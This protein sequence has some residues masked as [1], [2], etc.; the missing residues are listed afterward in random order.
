MRKRVL[1]NFVIV[2]AGLAAAA[3][4]SAKLA[5]GASHLPR[6]VTAIEGLALRS[7]PKTGSK[8]VKRLGLLTEVFVLKRAKQPATIGGRKDRW[9]YVQANYCP[10]TKDKSPHCETLVAKGWVADSLLAFDERFEPM[11]KWRAGRIEASARNDSWSYAIA[12]DAS[13]AFEREAWRYISEGVPCP[14]GKRQGRYCLEIKSETGRLYR[15]RNVVRAGKYGDLL[16]IDARGA[17]CDR[18][19]Y[20][21]EQEI[22]DR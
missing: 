4:H 1:R 9:V 14:G 15:Y 7:A 6:A 10:D 21:G 8:V 22:C 2:L 11:S 13:Y 12:A 16:Y 19:S 5:Q 20:P 17:L 18:L 3:A